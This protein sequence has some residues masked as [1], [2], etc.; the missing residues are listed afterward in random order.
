MTWLEFAACSGQDV[1]IFFPSKGS[2]R[3]QYDRARAYC[4]I[5]PVVDA[6]LDEAMR[7]EEGF[8][9]WKR[10]GM[11]GGLTPRQRHY[12]EAEGASILGRLLAEIPS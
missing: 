10:H 4:G 3:G 12:L 1:D 11:F 7:T 5:C 9:R 2:G 6:C 8:G